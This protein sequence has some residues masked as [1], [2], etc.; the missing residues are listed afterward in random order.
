MQNLVADGKTVTITAPSDISAGDVVNIGGIIGI[1]ETD[2]AENAQGAIRLYGAFKVAKKTGEAYTQ[3]Q[4]LY[5]DVSESKTTGTETNDTFFLGVAFNDALSADTK[6]EVLLVRNP[7]GAGATFT[8]KTS[9][10]LIGT[11]S[12]P[13]ATGNTTGDI[14]GVKAAIY[15]DLNAVGG[16]LDDLLTLLYDAGILV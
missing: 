10:G 8:P 5:Y 7:A 11:Q 12:S 2:I 16:R 13:D 9:P 6:S 14:N 1:A 3:G 4:V 15:T